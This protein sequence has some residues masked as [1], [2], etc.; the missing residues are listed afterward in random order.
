MARTDSE[1][2]VNVP[3]ET[4]DG[5][6][7]VSL[8]PDLA[9][10]TRQFE[11]L[12]YGPGDKIPFRWLDAKNWD[13]SVPRPDKWFTFKTL[14]KAQSAWDAAYTPPNGQ[15][16]N[17]DVK[18]CGPI[19]WEWD[20]I[21]LEEQRERL[22][23]LCQ[24]WHLPETTFNVRTRHS[25]HCYLTLEQRIDPERWRLI[26][27]AVIWTAGSDPQ[28]TN[29]G[30]LMRV[31]GYFHT[32]HDGRKLL[33]PVRCELEEGTGQPCDV[34]VFD[35]LLAAY[36]EHIEAQKAKAQAQWAARGG[37]RTEEE[38]ESN[39]KLVLSMAEAGVIPKR[40]KAGSNSYPAF[41]RCC[42]GVAE[43]CGPAWA[44]EFYLKYEP[45][46]E[47][48]FKPII[49]GEEKNPDKPV[50]ITFATCIKMAEDAGWH[51]PL[52]RGKSSEEAAEDDQAP[53]LKLSSGPIYEGNSPLSADLIDLGACGVNGYT[54][55]GRM[56]SLSMPKGLEMLEQVYGDRLFLDEGQGI[57]RLDQRPL[58]NERDFYV[59]LGRVG[60]RCSQQVGF[61][62]IKAHAR[63]YR[64]DPFLEDL[65]RIEREVTPLSKAELDCCAER[66]FPGIASNPLLANVVLKRWLISA[67]ARRLNPGCDAQSMLVLA[68]QQQGIGKTAFYR[69]LAGSQYRIMPDGEMLSTW[70]SPYYCGDAVL[71]EGG[72]DHKDQIAKCHRSWIADLQELDGLTSRVHA[73]RLKSIISESTD[74]I[75]PPYGERTIDL[76]R[77]F[78]FGGATNDTSFL[79]DD[80]NRRY[81]V[82]ELNQRINLPLLYQER[83]A[84]LAAAIAAYRAGESW[85]LSETERAAVKVENERY[86]AEDP[87]QEP[88][89]FY[90]KGLRQTTSSDV[91]NYALK[92]EVGRQSRA[93]QMRVAKVLKSLGWE[94]AHR[95]GGN[96]WV[97]SGE[98]LGPDGEH[99]APQ[100]DRGIHPETQVNCPEDG[101]EWHQVNTS[102]PQVNTCE[103]LDSPRYSPGNQGPAR[104][105]ADGEHLE[106]L[107]PETQKT[108]KKEAETGRIAE[109]EAEK[110]AGFIGLQTGVQGIHPT[111]GIHLTKV[112]YVPKAA[113]LQSQRGRVGYI[114]G[115]LEGC[116]H[117]LVK[118]ED[119]PATTVSTADLEYAPCV[120]EEAA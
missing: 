82:I 107:L 5:D 103:H 36:Q 23:K 77:R 87:W 98:H 108:Q 30:R 4:D 114:S 78:V 39:R 1:T 73:A 100:N 21:S 93:D 96:A 89:A 76:H 69:V 88:I 106:H 42:Y 10:A 9:Q 57:F 68:S 25:L 6:C 65:L 102:P 64:R 28:L 32:E 11:L 109:D 118:W 41:M 40:G 12:G 71:G 19:F 86:K 85:S 90:L 48:K 74:R 34:A 3:Q 16:R 26:Q 94:K 31:A 33:P 81:W 2:A 45:E 43:G 17:E 44:Y 8:K 37:E 27:R 113:H 115:P 46:A 97:R 58:E 91:L 35:E 62:L 56:T 29:P 60:Y 7:L 15:F 24:E 116:E 13:S 53:E 70:V 66:Y 22:A 67:V 59:A 117:R 101:S 80:E 119:G 38:V 55:K 14:P 79:T 111:K 49:E 54:K 105:S 20:C 75:R 18:S 83:E 112:R 120:A 99:L 61:S 92:I 63:K 47:H 104:V 95:K 51:N 110:R 50:K 72:T 52:R 84:L